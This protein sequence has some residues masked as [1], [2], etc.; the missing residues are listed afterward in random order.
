[1]KTITTFKAR[2]LAEAYADALK[3]LEGRSVHPNQC[4]VETMKRFGQIQ[5]ETGIHLFSQ[6]SMDAAN[7]TAKGQ[8]EAKQLAWKHAQE[9]RAR[10]MA[11]S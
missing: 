6:A 5:E 8:V 11:R 7:R 9:N 10:T 3:I 2:Q 1:M 4:P